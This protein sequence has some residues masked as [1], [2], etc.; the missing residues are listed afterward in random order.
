MSVAAAGSRDGKFLFVCLSD[1]R[2]CQRNTGGDARSIAAEIDIELTAKLTQALS[3]AG[4]ADTQ[5]SNAF[6]LRA[7]R[8]LFN[9]LS[10]VDDFE[11]HSVMS[12]V[13]A[14]FGVGAAGI[15]MHVGEAFLHD[16]EERHL[17]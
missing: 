6:D 9:S 1:F 11:L 12:V 13:N 16:A 4:N 2:F 5:R 15:A 14:N 10:V 17:D 8:A 7:R 3:H